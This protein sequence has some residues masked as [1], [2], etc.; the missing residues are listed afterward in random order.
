MNLYCI[1]II[2]YVYRFY[3][4]LNYILIDIGLQVNIIII[5]YKPAI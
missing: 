3:S 4:P 5:C 2:V 1:T